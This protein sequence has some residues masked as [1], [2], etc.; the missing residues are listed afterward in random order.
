MDRSV[1]PC[2]NFY[3]YACGK[4][5]EH[6]PIP[7]GMDSWGMFESAQIN[8]MKQIQGKRQISLNFNSK[9]ARNDIEY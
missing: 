5:S 2:D 7:E 3:D 1:D 4:W 6:N 9:L 8:V